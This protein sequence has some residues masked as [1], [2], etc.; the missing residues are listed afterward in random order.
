[1]H[2]LYCALPVPFVPV[3]LHA[4]HWSHIGILI[5]LLAAKPR[6][7]AGPLFPSVNLWNDLAYIR[8]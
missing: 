5:S 7:T 8:W 2:I 1:M 4:A 6:S 3:R